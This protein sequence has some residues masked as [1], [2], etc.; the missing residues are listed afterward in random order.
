MINS[1]TFLILFSCFIFN[2]YV[3]SCFFTLFSFTQWQTM[4]RSDVS[5]ACQSRDTTRGCRKS[6]IVSDHSRSAKDESS[7]TETPSPAEGQ[8][9]PPP[10]THHGKR[11]YTF[12]K[13]VIFMKRKIYWIMCTRYINIKRLKLWKV[14]RKTTN[15][16]STVKISSLIKYFGE[17]CVKYSF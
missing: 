1:F 13:K 17:K 12:G 16:V 15:F 10:P 11:S 14:Y 5:A 8:G 3:F 9:P 2:S 4:I 6:S 7:N